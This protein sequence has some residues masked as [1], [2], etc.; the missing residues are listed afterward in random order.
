MNEL[1]LF[2][3]LFAIGAIVLVITLTATILLLLKSVRELEDELEANLP[4]F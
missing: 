2:F 1:F 4:P 3:S